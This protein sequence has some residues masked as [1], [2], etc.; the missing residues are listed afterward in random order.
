RRAAAAPVGV[1]TVSA[2]TPEALRR[3][4]AVQAQAVAARPRGEA[5]ALCWTSN[6]VKT[7]LPYRAAFPACDTVE[8]AAALR[9]AAEDERLAAGIADRAWRPPVV[10]FLFT[11]QGVQEPGMTARLY[12][13]SPLYRRRLDE[14]DAALA[15]PLGASVRD[16]LLA[17]DPAVH[18]TGRAQPAL[19]AV[20][21]ALSAALGDLGAGP[22]AVLGHSVGEFA[23]AVCAG[24]LTLEQ[25]AAL[26][27]E[28]A[29]LM[30]ALPDGGGMLSVRAG[31]EETAELVGDLPGVFLAA[32]NGPR[33]TVLSGAREALERA[34]QVLRGH[35]VDCRDVAV[36]HAF[37][38]PLVAPALAPFAAAA[39]RVRPAALRLPFAST[40]Y[41]RLL[42][43]EPLDGAYWAAQAAEPVLF[44][45]ALADLVAQT[46]PTCL[47]EIG[48]APQLIHLAG[49]SGAVD[50]VRL[51]HP[52]PGPDA[53][54]AE[55][56]EAVAALY[57]SG[58]EPLWDELYEP[59]WR[60][61]E[62]LPAYAFS[63]EHRFRAQGPAA[64]EAAPA[65]AA[66]P[67]AGPG[68]A[69]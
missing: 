1:F 9:A 47:V 64:P 52:A 28:R 61:T 67:Q 62:R 19:F 45:D 2:D 42:A 59:A 37:H 25:A 22:H 69:E 36:S 31:R 54:A 46:A 15:P 3:N 5:A 57:R 58:L 51:L 44:A 27:A 17:G 39:D 38:S 63:A 34:A 14:A 24:A 35:G 12:R 11:G 55:L 18:R 30:D 26:V 4:L 43:D 50:G 66:A 40:R 10:G 53:G 49:R 23:A 13:Q 68:S 7:G 32:V 65:R 33:S 56:A 8:L 60:R 21:Y 29:R 41:G 6:R 16:L 48:P 20:G